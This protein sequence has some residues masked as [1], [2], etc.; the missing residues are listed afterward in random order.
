MSQTTYP[1]LFN[2]L[3]GNIKTLHNVYVYRKYRICDFH[4]A[5]KNLKRYTQYLFDPSI[6]FFL[7]TTLSEVSNHF[8]IIGYI[9]ACFAYSTLQNQPST[10]HYFTYTIVYYNT[11]GKSRYARNKLYRE[12]LNVNNSTS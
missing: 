4:I 2:A 3:I 10:T 11:S 1:M 7:S 12:I 9:G 8:C 6:F 5:N